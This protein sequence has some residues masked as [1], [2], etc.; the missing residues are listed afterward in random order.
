MST[1]FFFVVILTSST[2]P[3]NAVVFRNAFC[4]KLNK[5]NQAVKRLVQLYDSLVVNEVHREKKKVE[6]LA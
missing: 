4:N 2:V 5:E 6:L 1:S 3:S